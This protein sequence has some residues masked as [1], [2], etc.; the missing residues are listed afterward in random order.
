ME[1][2]RTKCDEPMNEGDQYGSLVNVGYID[3]NGIDQCGAGDF[4]DG[5]RFVGGFQVIRQQVFF[6]DGLGAYLGIN[7]GAA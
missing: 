7:A 3:E 5:I 6:F 2:I 4:G 1:E